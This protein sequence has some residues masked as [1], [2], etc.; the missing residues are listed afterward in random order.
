MTLA[1][2][3]LAPVS[4]LVPTLDEER[5]LAECLESVRWADEIVV[6]DSHSSDATLSIAA[7]AGVRVVQRRF[8]DFATHKNWALDEIEFRHSWVFILDAD[9]RVTPN[10][11]VE[12]RQTIA[13]SDAKCGYYVARRN[14]FAGKW[15][16]RANMYP[17]HQLRLIKRGAC[18]YE[19]RIVHE[20]MICNGPTGMLKA[21]VVHHD[22]KGIERYID[23]HNTYSSLEAVAVARWLRGLDDDGLASNFLGSGP[24]R[25][26]A[27]K[28]FAY[29]YMPARPF[30][31]FLWMYLIRLGFL[32][33][34]I[35]LRYCLLRFFYELQI[36]LKLRELADPGSPISRKFEHLL[37]P[38][39]GAAER[40]CPDCGGASVPLHRGLF[41]TRFGI[42]RR[43]DAW[44]CV[45]CGWGFSDPVPT[46]EELTAL[47]RDHYNFAGAR[48]SR[49][50]SLR[51]AFFASPAYSLW[52]R[53]D[54]DI[55]FHARH[56]HGRLLEFG[57]NE[58]RNLGFYR[59]SGFIAEGQEINP[60]AVEAA[61]SRGFT[62]HEGEIEAV[63]PDHAFDVV[64]L[65]QVLEHAL[66]PVEMLRQAHRLLVPGGEVWVSCP[67]I[68]SW[69]ARLFGAY[70]INW[71]VPFHITHFDTR[72]LAR[73]AEA[74]GFAVRAQSQE[75]PG[76]WVALS[77]ISRLT[78]RPGK[79]NR[80][81][82]NP[83]LV[84]VL[85]GITRGLLFPMLWWGNRR[86][87][88]DCLKL[89]A[90]AR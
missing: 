58:G 19:P 63:G 72:T 61:R 68:D 85:L 39:D 16:R 67:N 52:T 25:K 78:A 59:R 38:G 35:G 82:R 8:D 34:R 83:A 49:Y 87:N 36:D 2:T 70:W 88:G 90:E 47:Y 24:E 6:F 13:S 54:S 40:P 10:L 17:D 79:V 77:L 80:A 3:D 73:T 23:R 81:M 56:G 74:A 22:Y 15:I 62:V 53:F 66:D 27:I 32:D 14:I 76:L 41:D 60:V 43:L 51:D 12:I 4:V 33:G 18:R 44:R 29:R 65:S 86:G 37:R 11:E 26:R 1:I 20:H 64:V 7:A 42:D 9:E 84:I 21:P 55:S 50:D 30:V 69:L 45:D 89:I 5:N 48:M 31:Y 75:T 46:A 71:H 57:C 28:Q